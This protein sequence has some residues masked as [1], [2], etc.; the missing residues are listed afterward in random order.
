MI[1]LHTSPKLLQDLPPEVSLV[2]YG[3]G[4]DVA[5]FFVEEVHPSTLRNVVQAHPRL[6][7][8]NRCCGVMRKICERN[9]TCHMAVTCSV[10]FLQMVQAG[11]FDE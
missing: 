7:F 4:V 8:K 10:G 9:P 3:A 1:A 5:G 2:S 11:P 6:D